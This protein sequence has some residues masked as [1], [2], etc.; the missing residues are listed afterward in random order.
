M[1]YHRSQQSIT[2]R[3]TQS[4][5]IRAE[6]MRLFDRTFAIT[7]VLR[8]LAA[9]IAFAGV[10]SALM[11]LELERTRELGLLRALGMTQ[12]GLFGLLLVE[13]G[14]TGLIAGL[15]SVPVGVGIAATL[16][17]VLY[18]RCFGWSMDLHVDPVIVAQ[19]IALAVG[20]ALL[21]GIYPARRA[22]RSSPAAVLRND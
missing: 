15:L 1:L 9:V 20:A 19:G 8:L 16:V 5:T 7:R 17:Y 3:I 18:E 13:T 14:L 6:S 4:R 12:A 2:E 21:A 22:A 10:F 11:A